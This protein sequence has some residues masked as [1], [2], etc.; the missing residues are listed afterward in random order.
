M[1]MHM[2]MHM[3]VKLTGGPPVRWFV[4]RPSFRAGGG[5][6]NWVDQPRTKGALHSACKVAACSASEVSFPS[7]S[8]LPLPRSTEDRRSTIQA[9]SRHPRT[10]R[11]GHGLVGSGGGAYSACVEATAVD[12]PPWH[13]IIRAVGARSVGLTPR[14]PALLHE[15]LDIFAELIYLA[16]N[17]VET[18][19]IWSVVALDL[20]G[21]EMDGLVIT[22]PRVRRVRVVSEPGTL[23]IV[24]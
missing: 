24:L 17:G 21:G 4:I 7:P 9:R 15:V 11:D 1:C 8:A 20:L 22:P 18:D 2:C 12:I 3:C 23:S 19:R 14:S 13:D 16:V 6:P 10:P 5:L